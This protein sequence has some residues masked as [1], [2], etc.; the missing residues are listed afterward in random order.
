[1]LYKFG[2]GPDVIFHCIQ[3]SRKATELAEKIKARGNDVNIE[4][5]KIG[6][7]LHDIGR[8]KTN[9]PAHAVFGVEILRQQ[10][11][12][13][14]LVRIAQRHV[15]GGLTDDEAVRLGFPAGKYTPEGLEEKIVCYADKLFH[16]KYDSSNRLERWIECDNA[17]LE[18]E[19]L[20]TKFGKD[21]STW[22]RL[23]ELEREIQ[24]M[25]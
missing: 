21:S 15:G 7:L 5:V 24:S 25:L 2:C 13:D 19:K 17:S 1:M 18:I 9:D 23:Q 11:L 3:V 22:L 16:Y 14:E 10:Q 4:L 12:P 6:G 8:S 20:K